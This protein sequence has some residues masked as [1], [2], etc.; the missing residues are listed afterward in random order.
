MRPPGLTPALLTSFPSP[1]ELV[2]YVPYNDPGLQAWNTAHCETRA[3]LGTRIKLVCIFVW[4][5]FSI[6]PHC[7]CI[8]GILQTYTDCTCC[9]HPLRLQGFPFCWNIAIWEL[10]YSKKPSPVPFQVFTLMDSYTHSI[11]F[12][13][14]G[15]LLQHNLE[16][17]PPQNVHTWI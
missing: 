7:S 3:S 11:P 1:Y 5:C 10:N 4:V 2:P 12:V 8:P 17:S 16:C 6:S 15:Q 14:R 13:S 9:F